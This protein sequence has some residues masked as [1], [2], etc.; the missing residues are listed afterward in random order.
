MLQTNPRELSDTVFSR[1]AFVVLTGKILI[2]SVIL[3]RLLILQVF[4]TKEYKTLSD[5]NRIKIIISRKKFSTDLWS[6]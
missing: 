6:K 3:I 4:K 5:N 2:L 1:R